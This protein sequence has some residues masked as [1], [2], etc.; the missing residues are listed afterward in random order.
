VSEEKL[1][2]HAGGMMRWPLLHALNELLVEENMKRLYHNASALT[3]VS[4]NRDE[5][6]NSPK[7]LVVPISS[8]EESRRHRI[9][10]RL[11][12]FYSRYDPSKVLTEQDIEEIELCGVPEAVLFSYV[13]EQYGVRRAEGEY[14]LMLDASPD[15]SPMPSRLSATPATLDTSTPLREEWIRVLSRLVPHADFVHESFNSS[16]LKPGLTNPRTTFRP[17]REAVQLFTFHGSWMMLR[18]SEMDVSPLQIETAHAYAAEDVDGNGPSMFDERRQ[19]DVRNV[20]GLFTYPESQMSALYEHC[21]SQ[22]CGVWTACPRGGN[23]PLQ[24]FQQR[25]TNGDVATHLVADQLRG[26]LKLEE[27]GSSTEDSTLDDSVELRSVQS[28]ID[29]D[30][31]AL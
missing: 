12:D 17:P 19:T 31:E 15:G 29:F 2:C 8:E 9:W 3:S 28:A 5:V 16:A 22:G 7:A 24:E 20:A 6:F 27:D 10:H 30:A 11:H 4:P 14:S 21:D 26:T 18:H 25:V 23:G 1:K 13:H